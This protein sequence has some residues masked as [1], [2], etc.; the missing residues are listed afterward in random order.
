MAGIYSALA[1]Y[2]DIWQ[3][4][5]DY[6]AWADFFLSVFKKYY[7]GKVQDIL[8]LGCGTG[9]MT[10]ALAKRGFGMIGVDNSTEMLSYASK[11]AREEK[12]HGDILFLCQDIREFE[13]YGTVEAVVSCLD[14]VNHLE[15]TKDLKKC[16]SLVHNYLMPDGIFAFDINSKYKF[17]KIYAQNCFVFEDERAMCVW[18][19]NYNEKTHFCDFDISLFVEA[20]DGSYSRTDEYQRERMFP[21]S[22]VKKLLSET[23]F[24]L[25][26]VFGDFNFREAEDNDER[27]YIVAR[28]K[29]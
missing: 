2:Y 15:S 14:C 25:L 8:D 19:N 5:V 11:R 24:E 13:L 23:G 12:A 20:D 9:S 17:E 7:N 16:F 18:Q 21:L 29:K 27:I 1:P 26:G 28:A 10:L 4:D 6:N 22:T 3:S